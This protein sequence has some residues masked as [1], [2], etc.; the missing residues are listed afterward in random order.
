MNLALYSALLGSLQVVNPRTGRLDADDT[1]FLARQ[2]EHVRST[3]YERRFPALLAR[4]FLPTATDVPSWASHVVEVQYD[5]AG[6]AKVIANG[7]DDFPRVDVV[8]SES[9]FKVVSIGDA[10][11]YTLMDLRQALATGTPLQDRKGATARRV[12]ETGIDEILATGQLDT[13]EQAFGMVGFL[14]ASAVDDVAPD[15][16]PWASAT[17][18]EMVADMNKLVD[19]PSENTNEVFETTDLILSPA[20]FRLVNKTKMGSGTDTTTLEFFKKT[21][22]GVSVHKWHRCAGA[23]AEGKDRIVAYHKSPEV[24]EALVTQEFEQLPPQVRNL[25]TLI[26][27]HA[28]CSGVRIHHPMG[29]NYM[30]LTAPT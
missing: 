2:I 24:I 4:T 15:N 23:G 16:D 11:G 19:A 29:I 13:V 28:R 9:A 22:P 12:I 6:R 18:D 21:N 3:I 27:C 14:N 30:D 5:S 10:Y 25:E 26:L 8:A 7:S 1:A 20:L 17:P